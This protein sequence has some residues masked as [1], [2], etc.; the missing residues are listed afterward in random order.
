[1]SDAGRKAL[2]NRLVEEAQ[3]PSASPVWSSLLALHFAP[4]L[5]EWRAEEGEADDED[6]DSTV[7][8]AF[9]AAVKATAIAPPQ[10]QRLA[11]AFNR[12]LW[13]LDELHP[14][15]ESFDETRHGFEVFAETKEMAREPPRKKP[16]GSDRRKAPSPSPKPSAPSTPTH[17]PNGPCRKPSL[18]E[19]A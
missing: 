12:K 10:V 18:V 4:I 17:S 5:L 7:L 14:P 6:L 1:M 13:E 3:K 16:A 9:F 11:R 2:V 8:L 15:M 19:P